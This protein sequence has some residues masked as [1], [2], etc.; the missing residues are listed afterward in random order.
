MTKFIGLIG[1]PLGHSISSI[2]QQAAFDYYGLDIKYENWEVP[3]EKLATVENRLRQ[4]DVIGANVTIPYKQ[5]IV[6]SMDMLDDMVSVIGALNTI[7]NRNGK[8]KGY[9]TDTK[10]FIRNLR[11]QADF[12]PKNK[13]VAII[14]A[15][16]VARAVCFALLN[17][18]VTSLALTNRTLESA[19]MLVKSLRNSINDNMCTTSIYSFEWLSSE[20]YE[21]LQ[22]AQLVVN[23]T[24]IGMKHS[25]YEKSSPLPSTW[26][27]Q[28][29]LVYD[30]V[31]NPLETQLLK[32]A[33]RAGAKI[34][35]GLYM[36]L[37][38]GA[39]SFEIWT[40]REAPIDI[41]YNLIRNSFSLRRDT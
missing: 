39:D 3:P 37:Y 24:S 17:E 32:D 26:I 27:P 41:M 1:Y 23:C 33:R 7:V 36:L 31:Y 30:L 15:G 8:L 14:G 22:A 6:K 40:G 18:G 38:Q 9:N 19:D 35:N 21:R 5:T 2:F 28:N 13:H 34:L 4:P 11:E 16:G 25:S 29:S 10:G 12:D 20:F